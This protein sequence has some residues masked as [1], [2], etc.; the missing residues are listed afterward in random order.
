MA[1]RGAAVIAISFDDDADK[2][3]SEISP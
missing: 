2:K 1:A 3:V